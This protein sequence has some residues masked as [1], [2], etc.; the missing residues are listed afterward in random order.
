MTAHRVSIT[1]SWLG[2]GWKIKCSVCGT[3][4]ATSVSRAEARVLAYVHS[5][6]GR[7]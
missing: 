1:K 7:K 6:T 3:V 5:T 2:G 4:A